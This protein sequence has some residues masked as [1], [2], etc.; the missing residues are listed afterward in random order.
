M[1]LGDIEIAFVPPT[2][3][4]SGANTTITAV[5]VY[6]RQPG[7]AVVKV[8]DAAAAEI[9]ARKIV[10]ADYYATPRVYEFALTSSNADGESA[11][12]PWGSDSVDVPAAMGVPGVRIV[13]KP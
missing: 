10:L 3:S 11:M 12:S 5:T 2:K 7:G 13:P 4:V 1:A 6:E 9:T 8:R